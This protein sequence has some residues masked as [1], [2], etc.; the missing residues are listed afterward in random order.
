MDDLI[1]QIAR[2]NKDFLDDIEDAKE[3]HRLLDELVERRKQLN[4]TQTDV[5]RLM[6]VTQ[7]TVSAFESEDSNPRIETVQRYARAV[8]ASAG[9]N[10][11]NSGLPH[12]SA[13]IGT[14]KMSNKKTW[15]N[16][17]AFAS[18]R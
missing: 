12:I 13:T 14:W 8:N 2:D 18:A 10:V 1:R 4:L 15:S 3:L 16:S 9:F 17:S 11:R 6:G 7:P 5:A